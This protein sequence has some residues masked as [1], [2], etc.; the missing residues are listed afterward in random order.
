MPFGE[1]Y[2]LIRY[3]SDADM[4]DRL[5][6]RWAIRYQSQMGFAEFREQAC[7][8]QGHGQEAADPRTAA[9]ILKK[10]REIIG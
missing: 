8:W 2:E 6:L 4:E 7:S 10:V 9:D 3:A 1:G 5:F